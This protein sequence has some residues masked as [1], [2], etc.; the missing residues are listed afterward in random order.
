MIR[1]QEMLEGKAE[2][3]QRSRD[4]IKKLIAEIAHQMRTPLANVESYTGLLREDLWQR[5]I[6]S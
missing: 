5:K 3:A 4:E 2:D 6:R 1:V